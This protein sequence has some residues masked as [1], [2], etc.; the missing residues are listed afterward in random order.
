MA[1]GFGSSLAQRTFSTSSADGHSVCPAMASL[2]NSADTRN[3]YRT[4]AN[5]RSNFT[6]TSSMGPHSPNCFVISSCT[7]VAPQFG[8]T[9]PPKYMYS[10]RPIRMYDPVPPLS[11]RSVWCFGRPKISN[12][13]CVFASSN[14]VGKRCKYSHELPLVQHPLAK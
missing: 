1:M 11:S 14:A 3:L 13:M 5:R 9:A 7:F 12:I 2:A 6:V 4:N 8:F 10:V